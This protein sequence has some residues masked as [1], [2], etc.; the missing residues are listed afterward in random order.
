[1]CA[2][3]D[4]F[5]I[6]TKHLKLC[7]SSGLPVLP[8]LPV[9]SISASRTF[10]GTANLGRRALRGPARASTAPHTHVSIISFRSLPP[11]GCRL[12]KLICT[13]ERG[14]ED[15]HKSHMH[16]LWSA[17]RQRSCASIF[18]AAKKKNVYWKQTGADP[19]PSHTNKK[20]GRCVSLWSFH[21][22]S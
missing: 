20:G 1:M 8:M 12:L 16:Q 10:Y 4:F 14:G 6:S 22:L 18:D 13:I 5:S 15:A 2:R 21:L 11:T 17:R 3:P 19:P 9:P 7:P